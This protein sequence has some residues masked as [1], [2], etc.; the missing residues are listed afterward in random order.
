MDLLDRYLEAVRKHLPWQRQDDIIAELRANLE[1][2]LEDK[3]AELGRPLTS[4][5]MEAWL[6]ELGAPM[7]VAARYQPQRYLIGP[8]IFPMY[9]YVLRLATFWAFVIYSIVNA[10]QIFAGDLSGGTAVL[11]A[12]LRIPGVLMTTAFWVT[13]IF[14]LIEFGVSRSPSKCGPFAGPATD[15]SVGALPP[16]GADLRAGKKPRSF[17]QAVA[18]V[19]FGFLFLV[20]LLLIPKNPWLLL[21]PGALYLHA[22]PYHFAAVWIPIYW[23]AV[24]LNVL[25]LA[26]QCANLIRGRWQERKSAQS[27]VMKAVGL[28]PIV[29]LLEAPGHVYVVLRHPAVDEALHGLHLAAINQGIYRGALLLIVIAGMQLLWDLGRISLDAYRKRVA[30][31]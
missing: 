21:G 11:E 17:A 6:K 13:G 24:W 30:A 2:Q 5:E 8:A 18:E 4:G 23:C 3:E 25:Q 19:V 27:I 20:W 15:W 10:V 12:V 22:S 31:R 29:L 7:M 16:V 28:I 14:A 1:S 26:W 9:W